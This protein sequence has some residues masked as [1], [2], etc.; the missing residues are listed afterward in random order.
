MLGNQTIEVLQPTFAPRFESFRIFGMFSKN[1]YGRNFKP[2]IPLSKDVRNDVIQRYDR[3]SAD[4]SLGVRLLVTM[5]RISRRCPSGT[6]TPKFWKSCSRQ[7]FIVTLDENSHLRRAEAYMYF[8]RSG[9]ISSK[10]SSISILSAVHFGK[11]CSNTLQTSNV[12]LPNMSCLHPIRTCFSVTCPRL[13]E[14]DGTFL[15]S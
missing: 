9:S 2:G 7:Y 3:F 10:K 15:C 14:N 13:D 11:T 1:K 6:S 4:F 12:W 5:F 8:N